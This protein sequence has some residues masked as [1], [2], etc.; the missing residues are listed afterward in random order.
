MLDKS[1]EVSMMLVPGCAGEVDDEKQLLFI[2]DIPGES[3]AVSSPP[4]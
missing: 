3:R 2:I 1:R 4:R